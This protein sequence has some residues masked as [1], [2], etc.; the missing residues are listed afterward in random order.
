THSPTPM[1]LTLSLHDALPICLYKGDTP[2]VASP[3]VRR[4]SGDEEVADRKTLREDPPP[5]LV[6]NSTM[7]EYMLIRKADQPIVRA[8]KG[9][10]RWI[11]LDEAHTY[12][13]SHAAEMALLLRRVLHAF[14]VS[15]QDVR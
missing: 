13:G 11:V 5:I 3:T 8:S 4:V 6:T 10:L 1:Q 9:L 7:L 14:G 15:A 12:L 2:E